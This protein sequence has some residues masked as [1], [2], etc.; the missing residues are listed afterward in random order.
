MS[1]SCTIAEGL[2]HALGRSVPEANAWQWVEVSAQIK[3]ILE[4]HA[5]PTSFIDASVQQARE[6][7]DRIKRATSGRTYKADP[8]SQMAESVARHSKEFYEFDL[9]K[10][11]GPKTEGPKMYRL[12][13]ACCVTP[14]PK[15]V[16][17]RFRDVYVNDK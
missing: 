3:S 2:F 10:Q 6:D 13:T 14:K 15:S 4:R 1:T 17:W 8:L 12:Y 11:V 5:S 7:W 9:A 16:G